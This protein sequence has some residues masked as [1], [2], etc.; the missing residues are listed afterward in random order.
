M[1]P[2]ARR[3]EELRVTREADGT[4]LLE[5]PVADQPALHGLLARIRDLGL[6]LVAATYVEAVREQPATTAASLADHFED[7]QRNNGLVPADREWASRPPG[8]ED[9]NLRDDTLR[10][11]GM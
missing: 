1:T 2:L 8:A 11:G 5:G 7:T 10:N 9:G 6:P 3:F 4:T